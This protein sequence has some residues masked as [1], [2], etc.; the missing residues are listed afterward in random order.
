MSPDLTRPKSGRVVE[1]DVP[2]TPFVHRR[3]CSGCG[4]ASVKRTTH[5]VAELIRKRTPRASR[6]FTG[7]ALAAACLLWS[8]ISSLRKSRNVI[9]PSAATLKSPSYTTGCH[10]GTMAHWGIWPRELRCAH[11]TC[12][13]VRLSELQIALQTGS[14]RS[15]PAIARGAS[16]LSPVRRAP[17]WP[18]GSH[19]PQVFLGGQGA[20]AHESSTI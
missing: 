8:K 4:S 6:G 2:T 12:A 15:R 3:R 1:R 13:V 19:G 14:S 16:S 5:P 11:V 17:Q 9:L 7:P 20:S 18:R 10:Y